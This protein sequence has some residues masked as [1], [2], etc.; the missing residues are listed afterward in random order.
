MI[1]LDQAVQEF[2]IAGRADGKTRI[3]TATCSLGS[4]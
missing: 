1:T 4:I 3:A 2:L